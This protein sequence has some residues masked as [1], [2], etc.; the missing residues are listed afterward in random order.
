MG[1]VNEG[2]Q[3]VVV[4]VPDPAKLE[5]KDGERN[6]G[7]MKTMN[8]NEWTMA[9]LTERRK[10]KVSSLVTGSSLGTGDVDCEVLGLLGGGIHGPVALI[11]LQ[12]G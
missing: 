10:G 1:K 3:W 9:G 12:P 2:K 8:D 7:S 4:S 6:V 5:E 11:T